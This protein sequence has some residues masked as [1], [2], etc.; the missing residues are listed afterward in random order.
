MTSCIWREIIKEFDDK[1][2]AKNKKILLLIDNASCHKLD[3]TPKSI[4]IVFLPP[5]TTSL[6]QPL[7][8]G[9]IQSLKSHYRKCLVREHILAAEG[10]FMA[11]FLKSVNILRVLDIVRRTWWLVTLQTI[12]NCFKKAGIYEGI[13]VMDSNDN[14]TSENI[15]CETES[16]ASNDDFCEIQDNNSFLFKNLADLEKEN[17]FGAINENDIIDEILEDESGDII[18]DSA[19]S[20]KPPSREEALQALF[21]LKQYLNDDDNLVNIEKILFNERDKSLVQKKNNK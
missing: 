10:G 9:I 17:C 8:Q 15:Y 18:E 5:C 1:L 7:D 3:F 2:A 21:V 13:L 11:N 19:G 20:A 4:E 6:I 12:R 14:T 16:R